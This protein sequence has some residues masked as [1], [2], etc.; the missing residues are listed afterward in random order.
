MPETNPDV[1][2]L[3]NFS[4]SMSFKTKIMF[5]VAV[6]VVAVIVFTMAIGVLDKNASFLK[7]CSWTEEGFR[8]RIAV[9]DKDS[10]LLALS[11]FTNTSFLTYV[12]Y[13]LENKCLGEQFYFEGKSGE[14]FSACK[15]G[16]IIISKGVNCTYPFGEARKLPDLVRQM[17]TTV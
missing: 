6:V 8:S 10:A 17:N 5:A 9:T 7:Q 2:K 16:Q 1:Q 12:R 11:S 3:K 15:D 4:T 13:P 14:K